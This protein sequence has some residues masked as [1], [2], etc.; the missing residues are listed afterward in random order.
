MFPFEYPHPFQVAAGDFLDCFL[1]LDLAIAP[2]DQRFPKGS[3]AHGK[4][5]ESRHVGCCA[6][7]FHHLLFVRTAPEDNAADLLT[8]VATR[9]P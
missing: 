1:A 8:T 4:P 9:R 5:D 2:F 3:P 6:Q 7:P